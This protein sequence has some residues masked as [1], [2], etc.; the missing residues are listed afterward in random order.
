MRITLDTNSITSPV[1]SFGSKVGRGFGKVKSSVSRDMQDRW[2]N[3]LAV[4]TENGN[5]AEKRAMTEFG[6]QLA[7]LATDDSKEAA[8]ERKA[9]LKAGVALANLIRVRVGV[10][11]DQDDEPV[12]IAVVA[13]AS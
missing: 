3:A 12:A 4:V 2:N 1:K 9:V 10:D 7:A 13:D 11:E 8:T 5:T 6:K